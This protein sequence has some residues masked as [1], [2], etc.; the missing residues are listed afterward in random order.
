MLYYNI[1][2]TQAYN[3]INHKTYQ[4]KLFDYKKFR[5]N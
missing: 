4:Q 1:I 5:F 2:Y 3:V